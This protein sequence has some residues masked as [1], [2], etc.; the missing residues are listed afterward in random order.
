MNSEHR[1]LP[2]DEVQPGALLADSVRDPDGRVIFPKGT[3]VTAAILDGLR[4]SGIDSLAVMHAE[5]M[6]SPE[7]QMAKRLR[8]LFRHA[9]GGVPSL[10]LRRQISAYRLTKNDD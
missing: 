2:I 9:G 1:T 8:H 3:A 6:A 10:E 5:E 4:A 7:L